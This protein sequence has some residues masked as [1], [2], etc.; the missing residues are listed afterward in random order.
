MLEFY[1]QTERK[2]RKEH[3]CSVCQGTIS[4]AEKYIHYVG[5]YDGIFFDDKYHL[6]CQAVINEYCGRNGVDV[7]DSEDLNN[8]IDAEVCCN[9][10]DIETRDACF[11]SGM[12]CPK[13]LQYLEIETG[14]NHDQ[15]P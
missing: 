10:C 4:I 6:T 12:R 1:S 9:L 3:R 15:R 2:A 7:Y 11:G 13:V 5:R 14:E 8:W